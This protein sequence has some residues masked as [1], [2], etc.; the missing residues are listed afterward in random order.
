MSISPML[1]QILSKNTQFPKI[2][3]NLSEFWLKF[4]EIWKN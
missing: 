2:F 4:E 1:G 3:L